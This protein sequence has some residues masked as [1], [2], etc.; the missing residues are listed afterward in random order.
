M[1][2]PARRGLLQ[3]RA[4]SRNGAAIT[5]AAV[6]C[7]F[8]A[9]EYKDELG[10]K[11]LKYCRDWH[12]PTSAAIGGVRLGHDEYTHYY[13]AQC[14]YILGDGGWEKLFGPTPEGD[15]LTWTK[16]RNST[17]RPAGAT[18][19]PRRQ[20]VQRRRLQRRPGVFD[21]HVPDDHAAG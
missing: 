12:P 1:H 16:Y 8:N 17:V 18:A 5:A 15:T 2:Q 20:L 3:L 11:W 10:K 9:G 4:P 19:K 21:R 6:A 7:L 13:F 14:V